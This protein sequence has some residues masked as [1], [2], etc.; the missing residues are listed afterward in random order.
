LA[1]F[2][3]NRVAF[4]HNGSFHAARPGAVTDISRLAGRL[5]RETMMAVNKPTGEKPMTPPNSN[6]YARI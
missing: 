5:R 1:H 4:P 3:Q 2:L 6:N